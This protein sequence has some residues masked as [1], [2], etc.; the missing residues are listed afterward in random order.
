MHRGGTP[1]FV[2]SPICFCLSVLL[3]SICS[4]MVMIDENRQTRYSSRGHSQLDQY[5]HTSGV[6]MGTQSVIHV[7]VFRTISS[8][9]AALLT[10]GGSMLGVSR[11]RLLLGM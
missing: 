5:D 2:S 7:L 10:N 11:P 3:W 4:S 9:F 8:T 6:R 1:A